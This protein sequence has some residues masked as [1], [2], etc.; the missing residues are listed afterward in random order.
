MLESS[1]RIVSNANNVYELWYPES[2]A[3]EQAT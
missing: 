3:N 2:L 1:S